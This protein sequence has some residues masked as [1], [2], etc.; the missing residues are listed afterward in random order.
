MSKKNKLL[1]HHV[2]DYE[3]GLLKIIKDN[4][5]L[6]ALS[7]F[8]FVIANFSSELKLVSKYALISSIMF[9][10]SFLCQIFKKIF[11][12]SE[13]NSSLYFISAFSF[14]FSSFWHYLFY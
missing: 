6:I 11:G 12:R 13:D 5:Y 10:F 1:A 3:Q 14:F 2:I 8:S 9:L 4:N 7:S